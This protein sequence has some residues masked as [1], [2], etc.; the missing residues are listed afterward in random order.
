MARESLFEKNFPGS[1][2]LQAHFSI[3]RLFRNE[4]LEIL[5]ARGISIAAGLDTSYVK[6]NGAPLVTKVFRLFYNSI[7]LGEP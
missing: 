1:S 6:G 5:M 2:V 3:T 7:F 4:V